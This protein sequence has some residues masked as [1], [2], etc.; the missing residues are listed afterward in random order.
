MVM[1]GRILVLCE[2]DTPCDEMA[3][4]AIAFARAVGARL[5]LMTV[6]DN[7]FGTKGLSFPR[8]S[9]KRDYDRLLEKIEKELESYGRMA[10]QQGV[11]VQI[12]IR[13]GGTLEEI[14]KA[15]EEEK[16]ELLVL[17]AHARTRLEQ[18]I[19]GKVTRTVLRLMPCSVLFV[20]NEPRAL[21]EE[22]G[23]PEEAA[24]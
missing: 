5:F 2:V 21:P 9:L 15:V 17:S 14:L 22:A 13:E 3:G 8:P 24:A 7:P 18:L 20:K 19:S 6:L 11:P 12:V 4:Q 1:A 23:E 16:I 10:R